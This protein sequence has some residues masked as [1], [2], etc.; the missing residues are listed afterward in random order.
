[1]ETG[2]IFCSCG[3]I[4]EKDYNQAER[5]EMNA[6]RKQYWLWQCK[7]CGQEYYEKTPTNPIFLD[8]KL[9]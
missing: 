1:M 4:I 5:M 6:T 8:Q 7:Y 9:P 2:K 3:A